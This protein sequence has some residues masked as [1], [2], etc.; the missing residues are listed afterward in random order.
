MQE[1][2]RK[3]GLAVIGDVPWGTHF[4]QFYQTKQD[5]ID[6]LVPYFKTGLENNEFCMWVTADNLTAEDA[7]K[8]MI[9]AVKGFS[10]YLKKGQIK[11]LSYDEW[12]LK[13]G[14]FDSQVVLNGWVKKLNQALKKGY[15]GL[16]LTGNTFWLEKKD[17]HSFIDYEEAVNNVIGKYKMIA[18][19]TY[20]LQK[21]NATEIVDVIRNHEFALIKQEGK[22]ELFENSRYKAAK[23]DL[24]ESE[25]RFRVLSEA[26]PVII[27]VT[28]ASDGIVLY[29]NKSYSESL[30]YKHEDLIGKTALNVYYDP[31]ERKALIDKLNEQGF[32][33]NY[34]IR[35]KKADGTPF[36]ASTS[37]RFIDFSGEQAIMVVTLD[38][39]ERKKFENNVMRLDRE[40]QAI[41]ECDQVI[42]HSNDEISLLTDV[43]RVLCTTA[44]YRLAWVGIVE[45]DDTQSVR[46]VVWNGDGDYLTGANITWADAERGHGPTGLAI[47][48]GKTHLFQDFATEPAAVPWREAALAR[49]YRSSI[50]IPLKENA[51][52]VFSVLCLYSSE[53]NSFNPDE[54]KLLEGLASDISFGIIALRE[55]EKREQAEVELAH[56]ASFPELNP[57]PIIE[58]EASGKIVY[59][60]HAAKDVFPDLMTMSLKHPFLKEWENLIKTIKSEDN[61]SITRQINV[62]Q[63]WYLQTVVYVLKTN[64]YHIYGRNITERKK[65][66]DELQLSEKR[67]K[68]LS[69]INSL[70]LTSEQ[71][72]KIIHI[73][74]DKVMSYLN[75]D[76]FFN[77]IVDESKGRL[78]LNAYAG[79]PPEAAAEIEWLDFGTAVCGCVA[80]DN[81]P[82]ISVNVQENG[83]ERAALVRSY[84][85]KAYA[86]YPL[87][88]GK[89]ITGTVSFGT[90][91]R[92]SF[93]YDE[94]SLIEIVTDQ[95]SV[96]MQRN[97][98][99]TE[100]KAS[101]ER[102]S[103]AFHS[104]PV[105]LSIS[106]ISDGTFIDVN[107]SFLH[108][109]GY[110]RDEIVG[111][112]AIEI[113]IYDNPDDRDEIVR[114]LQRQSKVV[115]FEVTARTK[116]GNEIQVLTSAEKIEING[117]VHIIWTTIDI[118][119]RE[120]AE[121]LLRE[122]SNYLNNLLDYANAPIIVWDPHF[123]ISRFNP[124]FERLTGY[125]SNEVIGLGLD[126]LFPEDK[127]QESLQQIR[128]TLSGERWQVVEIPVLRVNGELRTVL[129][130]SANV[131]DDSGKNIIATIAQGQDI[132]ERKLA[133][134]QLRETSDYLNNLLN[135]AN[136]P[137]IVWDSQ[138]RI[139]RFN[140][141]F[142]RLTGISADEAI[143]KQ[144]NILFPTDSKAESISYINRT[145]SGERWEVVEIPILR[146]DGAIR[147]VLWNSATLMDTDGKKMIATIA[148]GQDI[149]ERKK[150]EE[151]INKLNQELKQH[152]IEL[153]ASN[154]ELEAFAYSVSHDL[155]APLRSM[156]GF[157]QALLEDCYDILN[158]ECKDYLKRI[159]SSAELMAQLIDDLLRLSRFTRVDMVFNNV[160]LS[161]MAQSIVADLKKLQP[162]RKIEFVI[163]PGLIARGDEKL[164]RV[165][166]HNLLENA[167]KFTGKVPEAYIEF[168][169]TNN[170]G[171]KT[172][173]IRD[174][175]AGFNMAY[176]DKIFNPFQRLHSV[177]EFPGT[178]IGLASVQR[179]IHRHGGLV[180]AEGKVG[181]GA[182]FYF[183]LG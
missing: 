87:H 142:E 172:Y 170:N 99:E 88:I 94:L 164:L 89:K 116:T 106:R 62:D 39:S 13:D 77:F 28:R 5:L 1:E 3:S 61:Q 19:C 134:Q 120:Q 58:L 156:E 103:N 144:L 111:Q 12:Y 47:R 137:I 86:S 4:C 64:H 33:Q 14:H 65:I 95:I 119:E 22:W 78:K 85:I 160:N 35:V 169:V 151:D 115:N 161:E 182:T 67:F 15:E 45:H 125:K 163:S 8:A 113:N 104:S 123:R 70:L 171:I 72:A 158:D 56:L 79:I 20:C 59:L 53:P 122:T 105:A 23:E 138:F 101:E 124:A 102:F 126:I 30:G 52:S 10:A 32:L 129:W 154:K 117:Q 54:V 73:I 178:G 136:A 183:T 179:I 44:G 166:L 110:T 66:E 180:R 96:A 80:R 60:N 9:K 143:G 173:Y 174:N 6:T 112:K 165:V 51:G 57:N 175:G 128:R 25:E 84:G 127:K 31:A 133:E 131:Y 152:S 177:D 92:N 29:I 121:D 98:A 24:I 130:N 55:K 63:N 83:D 100:L 40:L 168:G 118:S 176:V 2:I 93:T 38:I 108:L 42:V 21:C 18:L 16:R 153:E 82:I 37:I 76:A 181:E 155:R 107:E 141:A 74:A 147:I 145:M 75:C 139:T 71:P 135:Y 81:Q 34:E 162:A 26:S 68:I 149:T 97:Q 43:C 109:F 157:S 90:R 36:W 46:P 114:M 50:A 7:R 150:A 148:Q 140:H 91:S 48:T 132:T 159:Q 49:G 11:I 69:E 146:K 167:W 41:R 17:W 27:S